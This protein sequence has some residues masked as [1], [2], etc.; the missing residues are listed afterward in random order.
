MSWSESAYTPV[1]EGIWNRHSVRL[2]GDGMTGHFLCGCPYSVNSPSEECHTLP[3]AERMTEPMSEMCSLSPCYDFHWKIS[4]TYFYIMLLDS[5]YSLALGQCIISSKAWA[6][7]HKSGVDMAA[8]CLL[9]G[10]HYETHHSPSTFHSHW[11]HHPLF[12]SAPVLVVYSLP[13]S[14]M[15]CHDPFHMNPKKDRVNIK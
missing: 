11:Y 3:V 13:I 15:S 5:F 14:P 10:R 6:C 7:A 1:A 12:P 8:G 9:L 2:G 4:R